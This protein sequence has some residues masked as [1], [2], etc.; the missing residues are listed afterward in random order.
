MAMTP[1]A[2]ELMIECYRC[3]E[4][5][6]NIPPNIWHSPAAKEERAN[7]VRLGL[8]RADDLRAT[9]L[10]EAYIGALMTTPVPEP[11]CAL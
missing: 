5:G 10:G 7:L 11:E 4:P 6:A 3:P 1:L 2:I 9:L 8:I